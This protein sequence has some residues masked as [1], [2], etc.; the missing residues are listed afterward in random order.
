MLRIVHEESAGSLYAVLYGIEVSYYA[1]WSSLTPE[2]PYREFIERWS[3]PEFGAYVAGLREL[4][5]ACVDARSQPLFDEVLRH[6]EAF[7]NMT[8]SG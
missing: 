8:M 4:A 3:N 7:W 2:G 1:G 5:D 6:E